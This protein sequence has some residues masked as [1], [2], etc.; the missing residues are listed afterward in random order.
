MPD[1]VSDTHSL[2]WYLED[3]SRLSP[4]AERYF[5]AC[6][7]DGGHIHVPSICAVE[8]VY[9]AEKGR[10]PVGIMESFLSEVGKS[11][12]VL[13]WTGLTLSVVLCLAR[14]PREIVP[15]M[16]D[17]IIAAT[18]LDLGLP[19]LTRDHAIRASGVSTIW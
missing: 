2:I 11:D 8:M 15:D 13:R 19:L 12:T 14:V 6:E 9:L 18:A 3:D 4:A 16:P 1:A 5:E 7:N 10:I 17:T